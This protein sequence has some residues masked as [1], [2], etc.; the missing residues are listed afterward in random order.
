MDNLITYIG[1]YR[2][3]TEEQGDSGLGLEAQRRIVTNS[4]EM[5]RGKMI[6]EYQDIETGT[7]IERDGLMEAI[8]HC[9]KSGAIL[10]VKELSRISRAGTGIMDMLDAFKVQYFEVGGEND[11]NF[12]KG[13]K[14]LVAKDEVEK[15]SRRTT[16]ALDTIK[17]KIADGRTH[18]SKAGNVVT[19]LGKPENLTDKARKKG[20]EALKR[21]ADNDSANKTA[22]AYI[23]LRVK[24]KASFYQITKELNEAGFK[25]SKGN[26]YSQ[27][28]TKR[29]FNRFKTENNGSKS[30]EE[31][32][33]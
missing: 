14:L 9:A 10:L 27:M 30:R 8:R 15:V 4:V 5:A 31:F 16:E 11:S 20:W 23:K 2:V 24:D 18:I 28:Q 13:I 29:I 6:G 17:Q 26:H 1:Y 12:L 21:K 33:T 7:K 25:T 32:K 3:S 22:W 19:S